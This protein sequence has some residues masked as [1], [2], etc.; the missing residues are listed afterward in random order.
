IKEKDAEIEKIKSDMNTY[1]QTALLMTR[2]SSKHI[3]MLLKQ[4]DEKEPI[5]PTK[6]NETEDK[7]EFILSSSSEDEANDIP[8]LFKKIQLTF[9]SFI[10]CLNSIEKNNKLNP[11][12]IELRI[13]NIEE[14]AKN[15][16]ERIDE[17]KENQIKYFMDNSNRT[18]QQLENENQELSFQ[19]A[20]MEM[21]IKDQKILMEQ[22]E[23]IINSFEDERKQWRDLIESNKELMEKTE[24]QNK[25]YLNRIEEITKEKE[26]FENRSNINFLNFQIE[27]DEN[28]TLIL[29]LDGILSKN[30]DKFIHNVT[31][32]GEDSKN[33]IITIVKKYK[34][35]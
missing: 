19:N 23:I 7:T 15:W 11:K 24:E 34:Y 27:R 22:K 32:L 28:Q 5:S 12:L 9:M 14:Q 13:Q 25:L 21:A 17:F 30:K 16:I 35:F 6:D 2:K 20:K 1:Q 26:Q 4:F 31:K 3:G 29:V 10:R 18:I 33:A 8:A